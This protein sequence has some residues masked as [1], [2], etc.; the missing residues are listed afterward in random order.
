M[1]LNNS[2]FAPNNCSSVSKKQITPW[3]PSNA[4]EWTFVE[5][6][7]PPAK[8]GNFWELKCKFCV[9]EF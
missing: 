1:S 2:F 7:T 9:K 8:H 4:L 3:P 5:Y 6:I